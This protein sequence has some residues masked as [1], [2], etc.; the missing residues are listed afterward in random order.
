MKKEEILQTPRGMHDLVKEDAEF[1]LAL[2]VEIFKFSNTFGFEYI[3]TPIVENEKVFTSSLGKTSDVIKKEMFYIKTKSGGEKL[4]LR[5]EGTAAVLRAYVQN[6]LTSLPQPV[7]VF[8]FGPMFRYERPQRGRFR[9]HYQWGLEIIETNDPISDA[10]I[11]EA[12]DRF[13]KKFKLKNYVFKVNSLGCKDDRKKYIKDLKKYYRN[14]VKKLCLDCRRRFKENP[15]RLL[16]C[17]HSEDQKFK[18]NAPILT[19]YLCKQCESHFER[20]LEYLEEL[21]IY[22]ELDNNIVRGFD[23][24]SRTIFEIFFPDLNIAVGGGGRYDYLGEIFYKRSIAG[25]GGAIGIERFIEILRNNNIKLSYYKKPSIFIAQITDQAKMFALK[26]YDELVKNNFHIAESFTKSSLSSQLDI[27]NKLK[28]KYSII[29]G[30]QEL[31]SNSVIL[32]DMETGIQETIPAD[33]L[34]QEL[35]NRLK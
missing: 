2:L 23:Y 21:N 34:I 1:F 30:H 9:E 12:F 20:F 22:Y 13:F 10:Q 35:K 26:I 5:P 7:K 33:K 19:N 28:V 27:A 14:K 29:I 6:S 3:R 31:G 24:Y 4:V 17:K 16:D 11:I 25:V 18:E 32:K 8:Y 15:L